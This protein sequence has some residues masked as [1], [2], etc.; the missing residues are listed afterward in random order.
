MLHWMISQQDPPKSLPTCYNNV[1]EPNTTWSA[2]NQ[3]FLPP[4]VALPRAATQRF[5][6][7]FHHSLSWIMD[8]RRK[9]NLQARHQ[10]YQE[11][12]QENTAQGGSERYA[13]RL[14]VKLACQECRDRKTRCDGSRPIC[15]SCV[16]RK[17]PAHCCI[18]AA[19]RNDKEDR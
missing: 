15:D 11:E 17:R 8:S 3:L 6:P 5:P 7:P 4:R 1:R 14:K 19:C 13:K 9:R 10:R 18:Y 2:S 16:R 12:Q